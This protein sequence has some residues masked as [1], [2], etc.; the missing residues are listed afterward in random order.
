MTEGLASGRCRCGGAHFTLRGAPR[1][2]GVCHCESC[3][4]AGGGAFATYVDAPSA[5][6][7]FEGDVAVYRPRSG[8]ERFFCATCGS[9]LAYRE[10]AEAAETALHLGAF[11]DPAPYVPDNETG[12]DEALAWARRILAPLMKK[13]TS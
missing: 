10:S 2:V 1:G 4:R 5:A 9:P 8:V 6:V 7:A 3:R 13:E 12:A 11:D